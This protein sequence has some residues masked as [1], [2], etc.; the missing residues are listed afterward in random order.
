MATG[1]RRKHKLSGS[2]NAI[3]GLTLSDAVYVICI[4]YSKLDKKS[5]TLLLVD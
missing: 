1:Q 5:E 3:V 2:F 4:F